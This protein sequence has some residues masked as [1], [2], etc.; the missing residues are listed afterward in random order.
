MKKTA[1]KPKNTTKSTK[2][3]AIKSNAQAVMG[4]LKGKIVVAPDCWDDDDV[5]R[6]GYLTK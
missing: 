5:P 3:S 6:N 2:N 4:S 1:V